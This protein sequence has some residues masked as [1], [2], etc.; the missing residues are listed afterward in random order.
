MPVASLSDV[1]QDQSGYQMVFD[2]GV[3]SVEQF[4]DI[5]AYARDTIER[6]GVEVLRAILVL[7][8]VQSNHLGESVELTDAGGIVISG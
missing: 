1:T 6:Y 5:A 3:L 2:N 8:W 7:R 4:D